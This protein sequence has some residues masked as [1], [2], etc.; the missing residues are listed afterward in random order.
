MLR[1]AAMVGAMIVPLA[2]ASYGLYVIAPL[3]ELP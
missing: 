3:L 1:F 2:I